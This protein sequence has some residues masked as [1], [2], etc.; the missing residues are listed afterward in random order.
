MDSH[1]GAGAADH[2]QIVDLDNQDYDPSY[3]YDHTANIDG[4]QND[5]ITSQKIDVN[6]QIDT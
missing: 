3:Q 5:Q 6:D 2:D 4:Y 1:L